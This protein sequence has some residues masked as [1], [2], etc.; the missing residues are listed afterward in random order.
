[1]EQRHPPEPEAALAGPALVG[2]LRQA[3]LRS[4]PGLGRLA[5]AGKTVCAVVGALLLLRHQPLTV[6]LLGATCTA[7]LMQCVGTASAGGPSR[8]PQWSLLS[9]GVAMAALVILATS[10]HEFP[11]LQESLLVGIAFT[12]FAVRRRLPD[13]G[14]FPLFLFTTTVLSASIADRTEIV[15][16]I[17]GCLPLLGLAIAYPL[18]FIILPRRD[19]SL[20]A[21]QISSRTPYRAALA[22]LLAIIIQHLAD[23]PRAYW[24]VLVA[25]VITAETHEQ[26]LSKAGERLIMTI[27]GCLLALLLHFAA[28]GSF[29]LQLAVLMLG[30]FGATYFRT[31][32]TRLMVGFL[33]VYVV[34]LFALIGQWDIDI[35][36]IR[37]YETAIGC[38]IALLVPL[39][40]PYD[41]A[42]PAPPPPGDGPAPGK[43]A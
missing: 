9:A 28:H 29:A 15:P 31:A 24:S 20:P 22:A 23:L 2:R 17:A 16:G 14:S 18:H 7:F 43:A 35:V 19:G 36:I 25:V 8:Y 30:I 11:I 38:A 40:M 13:H 27:L 5:L 37:I 10:L 26:L 34:F 3:L 1:M 39:V 42:P 12:V 33:S 21:A 41:G 32:S 6:R 4:D